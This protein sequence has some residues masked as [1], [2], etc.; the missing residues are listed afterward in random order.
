[1]GLFFLGWYQPLYSISCEDPK[2]DFIK[3]ITVGFHRNEHECYVRQRAFVFL[4]NFAAVCWS[5]FFPHI[6]WHVQLCSK[7]RHSFIAYLVMWSDLFIQNESILQVF[8][9]DTVFPRI[10]SAETILFWKWK[11]WNFSYSFYILHHKN[12]SWLQTAL[13]Y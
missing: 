6:L 9:T 8:C 12:P 3:K 13:Y 5:K 11:M 1:M 10:V 7:G 2:Q 4:Q